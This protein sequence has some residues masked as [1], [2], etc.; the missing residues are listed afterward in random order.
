[1]TESQAKSKILIVDDKPQN[2]FALEKLLNQLEGVEV[3]QAGS[4][5]EALELTLD[6]EFALAIVDIQMPEMDGYELVGL[7]R[8]NPSTA[9]L[10]IIFISAIYSDEYH[11][12]KGYDAGAVDFLSKPFVPE[13]LLSK[14]GVFLEL[15]L[16][17][18]QLQD[19]VEQN[20]RLYEVEKQLREIEEERVH[21]L[22]DL[23][24]SKDRFFSIVSHDLRTPFNGLI[25]NAQL[26]QMMLEDNG[27]TDTELKEIA[28]TILTSAQGAHRLLENLLTWSMI[29]QGIME[30]KPETVKMSQVLQAV[31]ELAA[32]NAQQKEIQLLW[33]AAED[34][35]AFA[36][37]NMVNT[38][39][40]NLVSNAIK[41]TASGGK[42]VLS[43]RP[44]LNYETGAAE[45]IEVS[46]KD[47]GVGISEMDMEKL[48][49]IDIHH[50]TKGTAKE[51]GAG[52]G[53][54]LC[55]EM[56]EA[57]N[58]RL[59][60]ESEVNRGTTVLFTLPLPQN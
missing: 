48:F 5:F 44:Q 4:G 22:D 30:P 21:V 11:H 54:T 34:T 31:M 8:G 18:M 45:S 32:S 36:D 57:N 29:Q 24:A 15:Y 56:V 26:M 37:L 51:E 28:D 2:L 9:A 23:N 50:S 42:V 12:R 7:L 41:F 55:K 25:G 13:I 40:R 20:A 39:L 59:W 60:I 58:G 16:Q 17:R 53:L 3:L 43:A 33:Q 1:M 6:H 47:S 46:V 35:L 52:L 38:I 27:N 19:L 14:V 49:R 10:P